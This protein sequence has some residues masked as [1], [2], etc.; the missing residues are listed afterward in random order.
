MFTKNTLEKLLS[1]VEKVTE[2]GCWIWMGYEGKSG[3]G[4]ITYNY[5]DERVHRV[6]YRALRGDIP[7]GLHL[8]HLCR[9]RLC[10]NPWHLRVV[11]S[12]ENCMAPGSLAPCKKFA[13][14]PTCKHGHA[15]TADNTVWYRGYRCCL[16]CRRIKAKRRWMT[17]RRV[18]VV[19]A[20]PLLFLAGCHRVTVFG[21]VPECVVPPDVLR[22]PDSTKASVGR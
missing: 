14:S 4:R 12:R 19:A 5:R 16:T 13:E 10:C 2:S 21:P 1:H 11:T 9:V 8:D 17:L 15:W 22:H 7:L 18:L 3:Y 20:F 6:V